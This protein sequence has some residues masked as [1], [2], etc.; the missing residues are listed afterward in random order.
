[1]SELFIKETIEVIFENENV[2]KE[3][4]FTA[5]FKELQKVVKVSEVELIDYSNS[6]NNQKGI[7]MQI[8]YKTIDIELIKQHFI[9]ELTE[10]EN[11]TFSKIQRS[12][13]EIEKKEFLEFYESAK[14]QLTI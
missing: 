6:N 14:S 3:I 1:M 12:L 7:A 5:Y 11:F 9:R 4:Y 10:K 8:Y 2:Q 13:K